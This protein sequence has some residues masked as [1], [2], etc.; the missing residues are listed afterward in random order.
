VDGRGGQKKCT[1]GE[2][3]ETDLVAGKFSHHLKL[4]SGMFDGNGS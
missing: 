4:Y 1:S 3:K 2:E